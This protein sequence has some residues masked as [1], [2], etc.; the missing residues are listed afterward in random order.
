[1]KK[2]LIRTLSLLL[3]VMTLFGILATTAS[4]AVLYKKYLFYGYEYQNFTV[5]YDD[6]TTGTARMAGMTVHYLDNQVAY[7]LEPQV[8]SNANAIYTAFPDNNQNFWYQK[9][10]AA[11]REAILL[12]ITYGAPNTLYSV[13]AYKNYGYMAATQIV[14]WEFLM[15]YRS[16]YPPYQ[17][18]NS[19]LYDHMAITSGGHASDQ[20]GMKEGYAAIGQS[21]ANHGTI[22]SFSSSSASTAPTYSM[23]YDSSSGKY[24]VTLTDTNNVLSRYSF[25][26]TGM[27]VSRSGNKLTV[28]AAASAIEGK[29]VT[30]S[31]T[32]PLPDVNS[33]S[34]VIWGTNPV[35][36]YSE[37]ILMQYGTP[38]PM[39]AYFKLTAA[40]PSGT[41][42]ITKT[43]DT[44]DVSGYCFKIYQYG[45]NKSF[46]GKSGSDGRVYVTNSNYT[47]SGTK[48]Y[49]FSGLTDGNTILLEALSQKGADAVFPDSIRITIKKGSTTKYDQ[50]FSG[51]SITKDANG[52][53]RLSGLNL[54]GL[55]DGGVM[56]ITVNS[57]AVSVP[58]EIVK[59]STDGKVSGISFKVEK[60]NGSS[61]TTLGTY[62]TNS[63]GKISVP[64]VQIGDKLRITETVPSGYTCTSANPQTI[65]AAAGTNTVNFANA[66]TAATLEI[67]KTS[68]DG[69]VSGIKFKVEQYV[70]SAWSTKGTYTTDANG[71][72]SVTGFQVGDKLRITE[73]VPT[74]Y[75]CT[76]T[77]PQTVTLKAGA[78]TVTFSNAPIPA[79]LE[80]IKTCEDG[81][82][83]G[84]AFDVEQKNG[85]S[86]TSLGT[87][88]SDGNGKINVQGLKQGDVIRVSENIPTGYAIDNRQQEITLKK[89]ANTVTFVNRPIDCTLGIVK[90]SEDGNVEGIEFKVSRFDETNGWEL[91]GNY[92][93]DSD[94]VILVEGLHYADLIE[95]EEIVPEGYKVTS[96]NPQQ[97]TI[98][99]GNNTLIFTNEPIAVYFDIIK[100][101]SDGAIE[102]IEFT[103]E[104]QAGNRWTTLGT[105]TTNANGTIRVN[106]VL[107]G[108]KLRV[109]ETVPEGYHCTT[110]NPQEVTVKAGMNRVRFKNVPDCSLEIFKTSD[111]GNVAGIEFRVARWNGRMYYPI[112]SY[113][114]DESGK[115]IVPGAS[116]GSKYQIREIVPAGYTCLS[117]NP[118]EITLGM[119]VNTVTFENKSDVQLEI[120]KTSEDGKVSGITF[121][122]EE[123]NGEE[124][125]LLGEFT[126]GPRG[127]I[128]IPGIQVGKTYRITEQVP[129]GYV[130]VEP[131]QTVT[132]QSGENIVSFENRII[133]GSL[134]IIKVDEDTDYPL[135]GAGFRIY[136]VDG[137]FSQEGFTDENGELLFENLPYDQYFFV[138]FQAPSGYLLDDFEYQLSIDTDGE[139]I[140]ERITNK[141]DVGSLAVY[142]IDEKHQPLA[143]VTFLLEYSADDGATWQ[144]V[145]Q[146]SGDAPVEVGTSNSSGLLD[147]KLTSGAD[148]WVRYTGL[149]I[150]CA[151][152]QVLYRLTEIATVNGYNLLAEPAFEGSLPYE[153]TSDFEITVINTPTYTMPVTGGHGFAMSAIALAVADITLTAG[154]IVLRKKKTGL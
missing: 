113:T 60:A 131:V 36:S 136:N 150:S 101:A 57:K 51:S 142:K 13:D 22:P 21:L 8:E 26:G 6:G 125:T 18:T 132:L 129:R 151:E 71:K 20:Q 96:D 35:A 117:E 67:K 147:G 119:G 5:N 29:T 1:M 72:I 92:V 9:L 99:L 24:T 76:S 39:R 48:V 61:W 86:W 53:A 126:T 46:Y 55:K 74:G 38:S 94:G 34:P 17:C 37:Q 121:T 105:Y 130:A 73:T 109:T 91:Y 15:G 33:I 27:T 70:N 144:P 123:M 104:K 81:K 145:Q 137:D 107:V 134:K 52:D 2:R 62:T 106:G 140:E 143:G 127:S 124:A 28:T 83:A 102:G 100:E 118:Q 135:E 50:T 75:T 97:I 7:C 122:V 58:V 65:T 47:V 133:R 114:T 77:N 120:R 19:R 43:S 30:L 84:I 40:A 32:S 42:T 90:Q 49:T 146:R 153:G 4:A 82:V 138:E 44:D 115:I 148:G 3:T 80:I 56:T 12:A 139:V 63:N 64:G 154:L 128:S 54:T 111:D 23:T 95:V 14:I 88:I 11:K 68:T 87:Y 78:N 98:Q 112:V 41:A 25:S 31:A 16:I 110:D 85:S 93:T 103:V 108:D 89:G 149:P 141:S 152:G 45:T 69:N 116:Y 59:T 10:S 66:P 79:T